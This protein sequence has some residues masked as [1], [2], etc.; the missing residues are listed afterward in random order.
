MRGR[1]RGVEILDQPGLDPQLVRRSLRDV[2]VA[3]SLFGGT[4]AV[5]KELESV[6]PRLPRDAILLDVGTG[7]GDIPR[8]LTRVAARRGIRLTTVG[9]DN[10][11][12]LSTAPRDPA[13]EILCGDARALPLADRSVDVVICSQLLHHFFDGEATGVLRELNRVARLQVIVTDLR[14]SR[15]AALGIWSASFLLAFHPVSRHDGVVSV[16]RGFRPDEL[17]ATAH[18]ALGH[19]VRIRKHPGFRIS[20]TWSPHP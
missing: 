14:R 17:H 18:E 3:N 11:T 13:V 10:L 6:W 4:R 7:M 1:R 19:D 5:L 12:V 8:R 20:A 9:L 15:L 16:M 2:A